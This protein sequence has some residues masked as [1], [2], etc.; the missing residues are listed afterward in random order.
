MRGDIPCK[1]TD[2]IKCLDCGRIIPIV[3]LNVQKGKSFPRSDKPGEF[4]Q[5]RYYFCPCDDEHPKIEDPCDGN[6][7]VCAYSHTELL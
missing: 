4:W 5:V 1:I 7:V 2:S 3:E 6:L